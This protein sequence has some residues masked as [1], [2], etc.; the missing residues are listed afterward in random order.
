MGRYTVVTH[1]IDVVG[2]G[3]YG[4]VMATT[5]TLSPYHLENIGEFTRG[6][7]QDWLDKN[8]GDFQDIIDFSAS[9][10]ETVIPWESEEGE[11]VYDECMYQDA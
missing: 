4:Q 9:S 2:H 6:N 3:W 10:D 1:E 11:M 5:Y 7:V 8:A